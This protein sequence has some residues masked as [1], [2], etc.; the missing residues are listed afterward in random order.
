MT[1]A[2]KYLHELILR[3]KMKTTQVDDLLIRKNE[4]KNLDL[5]QTATHDE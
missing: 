1:S 5:G 3:L 4:D 2:S